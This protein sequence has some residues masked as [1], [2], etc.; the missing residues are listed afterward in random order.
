MRDITWYTYAD[1]IDKFIGTLLRKLY[2][3]PHNRAYWHR[4]IKI[5]MRKKREAVMLAEKEVANAF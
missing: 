2:E 5:A 3:E 4:E 1:A